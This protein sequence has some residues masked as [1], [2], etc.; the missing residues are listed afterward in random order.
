MLWK[1]AV[2]FT[3]WY[4]K[5]MAALIDNSFLIYSSLILFV[6]NSCQETLIDTRPLAIS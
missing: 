6:I 3:L 1:K 5:D 4:L 2:T